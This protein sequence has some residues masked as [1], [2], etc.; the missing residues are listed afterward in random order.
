MFSM[1]NEE[2]IWKKGICEKQEDRNVFKGEHRR[3]V[4]ALLP[5]LSGRLLQGQRKLVKMLSF[6]YSSYTLGFLTMKFLPLTSKFSTEINLF[7]KTFPRTTS[8]FQ[9]RIS[10]LEEKEPFIRTLCYRQSKALSDLQMP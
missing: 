9:G 4:R 10:G 5:G 7:V 3:V 2:S 8:Q 6:L 1:P